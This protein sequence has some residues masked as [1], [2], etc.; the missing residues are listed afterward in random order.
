[1]R[2]PAAL[3]GSAALALLPVAPASAAET[4]VTGSD[5]LVWDP[6]RVTVALGDTVRWTFPNTTQVHNVASDSDNWSYAS[7]LATPAPDGTFTFT[8]PG[9]YRFICEVHSS[10]TGDVAVTDASGEPPPP[11]PPPPPSEQPFPNDTSEFAFESGGF[12]TTR[13]ALR[14]SARRSAH[15]VRVAFRVS[16]RSV[17]RV[18]L[19]RGGRTVKRRT[20]PTARRGS[21]TVRGLRAGRYVAR[22]T[23]TD[24]AGN[25]SAARRLAVR[26]R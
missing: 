6:P 15:R 23:A 16:E 12:D 11:P 13:P 17:V 25:R 20:V 5:A 7:P 22:V 14:A 3:L 10:M 9:T 26:V 21:V 1:M 24:V 8:A 4:V 18:E 19:L 2:W